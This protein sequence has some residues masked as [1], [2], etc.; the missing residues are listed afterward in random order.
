MSRQDRLIEE[1]KACK[2]AFPYKD[3][4]RLLGQLGFEEKS[5]GGGSRRRFAHVEK[6]LLI[7]LHEPHP[8]KEVKAYMV[9]EV[10]EYLVDQGLI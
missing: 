2:G 4:V 8:G 10:R 1:L 9:R 3:L 5:T 7:K 6:K